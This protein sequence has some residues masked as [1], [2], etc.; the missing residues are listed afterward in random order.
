LRGSISL[1]KNNGIGRPSPLWHKPHR[2]ASISRRGSFG[3]PVVVA[4]AGCIARQPVEPRTP[5]L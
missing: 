3:K 5:C 2:N 4:G 1:I